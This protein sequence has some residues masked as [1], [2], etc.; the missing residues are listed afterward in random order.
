[1]VEMMGKR[2]DIILRDRLP[3]NAEPPGSVLVRAEIT[4]LDAFYS[5]KHGPFPD[6]ARDEWRLLGGRDTG[7]R[8]QPAR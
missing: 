3:F 8:R 6:I 5:R 7:M 1:M 2:R 4:A